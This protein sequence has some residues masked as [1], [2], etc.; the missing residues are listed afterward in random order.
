MSKVDHSY[1]AVFYEMQIR[2]GI[3]L[4]LLFTVIIEITIRSS[5]QPYNVAGSSLALR[6]DGTPDRSITLQK[7][8]SVNK[9]LL[10]TDLN[11]HDVATPWMPKLPSTMDT[12]YPSHFYVRILLKKKKKKNS[13][14][15]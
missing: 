12:K 8:A 9:I 15:N 10:A 2:E 14:Y 4:F 7:L 11:A 6:I 1:L 5:E 13:M 3:L